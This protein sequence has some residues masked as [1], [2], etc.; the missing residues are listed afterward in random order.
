MKKRAKRRNRFRSK[1]KY[2]ELLAIAQRILNKWELSAYH[3]IIK[4]GNPDC[5]RI[6]G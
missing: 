4:P 2:Q 6:Y 3:I 5:I 1:V